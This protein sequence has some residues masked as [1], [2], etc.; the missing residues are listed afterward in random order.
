M[1]WKWVA[2]DIEIPCL[3]QAIVRQVGV[4]SLERIAEREIVAIIL[5]SRI[6]HDP[7]KIIEHARDEQI[8]V[9]L[10]GRERRVDGEALFADWAM[11]AS[12][13]PIVSPDRCRE[14]ARAARPRRRRCAHD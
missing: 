11:I 3:L 12:L 5:P 8:A 7:V 9:A 10:R 14:A 2:L 6:G 1:P 4:L 13:S